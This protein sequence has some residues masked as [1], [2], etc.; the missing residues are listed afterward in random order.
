MGDAKITGFESI[1]ELN[2]DKLIFESNRQFEI[3]LFLNVSSINSEYVNSE[4]PGVMGKKVEFIPSQ[5]YKLGGR[6][7]YKNLFLSLQ[8]TKLGDQFTDASNA[9]LSNLSGVIGKI[10]GYQVI[11]LV[12]NYKTGKFK[13]ETGINNLGNEIYFTRRATGYPGPG[14]IPS[15]PR[16][17]YM[18]LQYRL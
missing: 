14:I 9:T 1:V 2:L 8:L 3:S 7:G 5:N 12:L 16:N 4:T 13:V 10:P 6:I 18:T 17:C 11:D 15:P